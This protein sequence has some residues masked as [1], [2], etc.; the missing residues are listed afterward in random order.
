MTNHTLQRVKRPGWPLLIVTV[1]ALG[2]AVRIFKAWAMRYST[3]GDFGIVALMARHMVHGTDY[4]VFSYGVAYMGG[5]E[6]LTSALMSFIL[7]GDHTAFPINLGTALVGVFLLPLVYVLA[8][9]AGGRRA[10]L[11]ALLY[12]VVGSDTLL[13]YS[14]APRGG[15]MSLMAGG[16]LALWLTCR[17]VTLENGGGQVSRR[18]FG[19]IGFAAGLA[20]WATQ[21]VTVYVAAAVLIVLSGWRWRL[22]RRGLVPGVLGFFLGSLPWWWWNATH[23]WASLDLG[24]DIVKV[25]FREGL[26]SFG[27]LLLKVAEIRPNSWIGWT[28]LALLVGLATGFVWIL[29]R[30][31][32]QNAESKAFYYRLSVPVLIVVAAL[33]YSTSPFVRVSA[34]RYLMPV[35]PAV[36]VMIGVSCDRLLRRFRFPWGWIVAAAVLPSQILL[37]P[38][39]LDGAKADRTR[40]DQTWRLKA[41][42]APSCDGVFIGDYYRFHWMNFSSGEQLCV[43]APPKER[44]APYAQRAELALRPAFLDQYGD[45]QN[46]LEATAAKSYGT[47]IGDFRVD[48]RLT[49]PTNAWGYV[50]TSLVASVHDNRG[51]SPGD[52]LQN[53][54]IGNGWVADASRADPATL[55]IDFTQPRPICGLRLLSA[56][57][58]YPSL[59]R[60]EGQVDAAAPWTILLRNASLSDYF[61]S[62]PYPKLGLFQYHEE[63]RWSAPTGG[64]RSLRI[65]CT[66]ARSNETVRIDLSEVLVLEQAAAPD[67]PLPDVDAVARLLRERGVG[68]A[69]APRWLAGALAARSNTACRVAAPLVFSRRVNDLPERDS[70]RPLPIIVDTP[71]AMI[72]DLRDAPCSRAALTARG[73]NWDETPLGCCTMLIVTVPAADHDARRF[74]TLCWTETGCFGFGA[75]A[76]VKVKSQELYEQ[77]ATYLKQGAADRARE[78]F[79]QALV[80][81]PTHQTARRALADALTTAGLNEAAGRERAVLTEQTVPGIPAAAAFAE[82]IDFLG[83]TVST[84]RVQRGGTFYMTC[85]WRCPPTARPDRLKVFVHATRTE[86][87][88]FQ[89]DH[90]LLEG[91]PNDDFQC[92]PYAGEVFRVDRSVTVPASVAPGAYRILIG[93]CHPESRTRLKPRTALD[94]RR[95]AIVLPL[96]LEILP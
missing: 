35:V 24:S 85:Y 36:A 10:G 13:H 82:G 20:W 39:L 63:L 1:I 26:L 58:H 59:I 91:I 90:G 80:V 66:P 75:A 4:P 61:W 29:A 88:C 95:R 76:Y 7:K 18:A 42:V 81:D 60:V 73:L 45:L 19:L 71:T 40:W 51:R 33:F 93:L 27:D 22:L 49:P 86:A 94:V 43:A 74:P 28:R 41:E 62:G 12:C 92:Q 23:Y 52:T 31:K 57:E 5:L 96:S 21:L 83:I 6:P 78:R 3:N 50:S 16:L 68:Q 38:H 8:R 32:F 79:A 55:T 46:F 34:S 89:D 9:D 37:M 64:V 54:T 56:I 84:Q 25:T 53:G 17:V 30:D 87:P 70:G 48:Y 14:V 67:G 11:I 69:Y 47:W 2:V 77:G 15:Y 65:T 72:M 44:Y